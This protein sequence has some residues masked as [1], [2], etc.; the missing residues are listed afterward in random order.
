MNNKV[1]LEVVY[2][3]HPPNKTAI[4]KFNQ[5]REEAYKFA[6]LMDNLCPK[7]R[8]LNEAQTKLEEVIMWA[9]AAIARHECSVMP[10]TDYLE[11][12]DYVAKLR[13]G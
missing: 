11:E 6:L 10:A 13:E 2:T 9:N 7:S 5:L 3:Y 12:D 1:N 8:E 4:P